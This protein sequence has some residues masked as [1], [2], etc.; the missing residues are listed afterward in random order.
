ML[1]WIKHRDENTCE[2]YHELY[3]HNISGV[4]ANIHK[5]GRDYRIQILDHAPF[6]SKTLN[7][8]KSAGQ[9]IYEQVCGRLMV[10]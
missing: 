1:E 8:A 10:S 5:I 9:H 7:T 4:V 2:V 3:D 6:H